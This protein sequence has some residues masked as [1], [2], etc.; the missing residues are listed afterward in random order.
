MGQDLCLW[1]G[2]MREKKVL[3]TRKPHSVVGTGRTIK[4]SEAS[5]VR[6]VQRAKQREFCI[7][8][9]SSQTITLFCLPTGTGVG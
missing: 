8:T 6:G 2:A 3:N 4:V 7:E 5:T 9:S 1:E